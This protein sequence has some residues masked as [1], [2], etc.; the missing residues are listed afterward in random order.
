MIPQELRYTKSHE[1]VA[2]E[3]DLARIG[4]TDHAQG[5]LGDV[6]FVELPEVGQELEL[7]AVAAT[8]ESVK[9]VAEVYAPIAGAV[10]AGNEELDG[11]PELVNEDPYGKGWLFSVTVQDPDALGSLMDAEAYQRYL[12]EESDH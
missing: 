4:I 12:E 2:L 8:I 1:W 5:E 6:V 10:T 9:T 11:T 3:G 7:G